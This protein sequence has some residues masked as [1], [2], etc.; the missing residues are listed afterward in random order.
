MKSTCPVR[1]T[2]LLALGLVLGEE[3]DTD[4]DAGAAEQLGG[5]RD[6]AGD[7]VGLDELGADLALAAGVR[8]HG[9]VGH[10][11]A[12]AAAGRELGDDVLDPGVVG[13]AG[14]WD[15]ELPAGS[16]SLR[17][18]SLMLNGGLAMT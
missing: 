4:R 8:G 14:R 16:D 3:P 6:H 2:A 17:A 12:G 11:D 13:V 5:Q 1:S 9:P 10:D 7:Q 18:Q 15:A